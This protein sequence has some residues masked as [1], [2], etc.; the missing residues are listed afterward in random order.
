VSIEVVDETPSTNALVAARATAGAAEGLV[1]VAEHQT[2]GR[3]R[4]DRT[5]V[6]PPRAA[7]TFSVLLRPRVPDVRWPWI[8]LLAGIS[9]VDAVEDAGGPPCAL[10]WP[11]DVMYD[12]RK[13]A[14]LLVE[15]LETPTGPAAVLGVGLNVSTAEEEL[16]VPGAGS[17]AT[18]GWP[19]LDRALLLVRIL[20]V[21]G[22]R[23]RRWSGD[24]GD[25]M[26]GLLEDYEARCETVGRSVRVHL[27]SGEELVGPAVGI[28]DDGGLLVQAAQGVVVVSAGDVVHVR[29]A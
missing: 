9:V 15:R 8:P 11:N 13:L 3:G 28:A 6:T 14:G 25:P 21:L 19:G 22:K 20:E 12:G 27:P 7:L 23:L 17:L 16:P 18:A 10:K 4:L 5:W 1:V 2:S 24:S 29:P 26:R